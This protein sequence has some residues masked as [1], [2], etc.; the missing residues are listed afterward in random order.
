M[1]NKNNLAICLISS[2][3][4]M[5]CSENDESSLDQ[6]HVN[7]QKDTIVLVERASDNAFLLSNKSE[8]NTSFKLQSS[9]EK[10]LPDGMLDVK[11]YLGRSYNTTLGDIGNPDGV[12][13]P[14]IDIEKYVTD[15]P[16]SYLSKQIRNSVAQSFS[17]SSFDRYEEKTKKSKK[18]SGGLSLNLGVFSVGAKHKYEKAFS[19]EVINESKRVFGELNVYVK[20]ASYELFVSSN[21]LNK[22]KEKYLNS[23][24]LDELYNTPTSEF[25]DNYGG[26]VITDFVS[27]GRANALFSGVYTSNSNT[28]TMEKSMDNSISASYKIKN[29]DP[30]S[31]DLGIGNSKGSAIAKSNNISKFS[32]TTKTYGGDY[33]LSSFTIPK[34][35]DDVN[36][37][38]TQWASSLNDKSKTVL[39]DINDEGLH[40]ISDFILEDNLQHD[41]NLYLRGTFKPKK[42]QEPVIVARWLHEYIDIYRLVII[43]KT[44]FGDELLIS[45]TKKNAFYEEIGDYWN[46]ERMINL[47]KQE[48]AKKLDYFKLKAIAVLDDNTKF[49]EYNF[50]I[51]R[52]YHRY[53][54]NSI[55]NIDEAQMKKYYD[56]HN[57]ILYL[58]YNAN[59]EKFAYAIHDDYILDTYGIR[60]WVDNISTTQI[61]FNE[62][63]NY[64]IVGL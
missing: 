24:F 43:L 53:Y 47:A 9:G 13:Y 46:S 60:E 58:L 5:S 11:Y 14:V 28:E 27:G 29:S 19:S 54:T 45:D 64:T 44:R 6:N 50:Y 30:S 41:I 62:L 20:D 48:A 40:P 34:S 23:F 15:Y 39:V 31:L 49:E 56:Q 52:N 2:A 25:V 51:G 37:N 26:F 36:I 7:A 33:G 8:R 59:G 32:T 38:L 1:I 3:I 63:K 16:D 61:S 35:I 57:K 22:I 10:G 12:K 17:F 21:T 42:L 55:S 4:I 18:V